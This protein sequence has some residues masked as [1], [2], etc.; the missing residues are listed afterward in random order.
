MAWCALE[1]LLLASMS[2]CFWDGL[3]SPPD[4][5]S[6]GLPVVPSPL[7]EVVDPF[8]LVGMARA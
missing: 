3:P 8:G 7:P 1:T 4:K 5:P 6:P 2:P